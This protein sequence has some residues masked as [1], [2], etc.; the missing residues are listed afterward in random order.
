MPPR[1]SDAIAT[2]PA[3]VCCRAHP[4]C[5]WRAGQRPSLPG[6]GAMLDAPTPNIPRHVPSATV[7]AA[8]HFRRSAPRPLSPRAPRSMLH[9]AYP[10]P[11]RP[12]ATRARP[13]PP[14]EIYHARHRQQPPRH[15]PIRPRR[16]LTLY[17]GILL[18]AWYSLSIATKLLRYSAACLLSTSLPRTVSRLLVS[19]SPPPKR[20]GPGERSVPPPTSRADG[21]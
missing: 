3:P 21:R 14:A 17:C 5:A 12:L 8:H 4:V 7:I 1:H 16:A 18:H 11:G 9:T 2:P 13:S 15:Q 6:Y 20:E 19:A 10:W